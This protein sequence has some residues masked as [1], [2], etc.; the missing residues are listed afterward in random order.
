M[1]V[2]LLSNLDSF[3][4]L[5]TMAKT[6]N[7]MLNKSGESGQSCPVPDLRGKSVRFSPLSMILA[8]R[9]FCM[10]FIKVRYI[11]SVSTVLRG[12]FFCF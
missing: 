12:F 7:P 9:L 2:L 4:Y 5:T 8:V 6:S 11:L 3:S 1:R 10:A